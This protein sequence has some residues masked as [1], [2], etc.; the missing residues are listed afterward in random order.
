MTQKQKAW[1]L[2][3]SIIVMSAYIL[4]TFYISEPKYINNANNKK[5]EAYDYI[6]VPDG[7]QY[8]WDESSGNLEVQN[9]IILQ[10]DDT[11]ALA[12]LQGKYSMSSDEMKEIDIAKHQYRIIGKG[13]IYHKVNSWVGFNL[14]II[15][16]ILIGF[17]LGI[18]FVTQITLLK[19]LI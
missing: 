11:K 9:G 3:G 8:S 16:Q 6:S 17:L 7:F 13:T 5:L 10:V 19:D 4:W 1:S 12:K 15:T 18:I 14:M 2:L